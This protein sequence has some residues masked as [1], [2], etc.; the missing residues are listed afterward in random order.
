MIVSSGRNTVKHNMAFPQSPNKWALGKGHRVVIER[1]ALGS[2]MN[3]QRNKFRPK[4]MRRKSLCLRLALS[5]HE[6][7]LAFGL[8][9]DRW[10]EE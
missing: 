3:V 2:L 7:M 5:C 1:L 10:T 9:F 4:S 6:K 8:P